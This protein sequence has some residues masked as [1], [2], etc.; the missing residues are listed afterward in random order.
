MDIKRILDTLKDA[1]NEIALLRHQNEILSAKVEMID[2]FA[3]VL[4][5]QPT[6]NGRGAAPDVRYKLMALGQ[7]IE[8]EEKNKP[9]SA[10][11]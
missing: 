7:D 8:I 2:L 11:S 3:M 4:N 10:A 5:T 1:D 9:Q 6:R